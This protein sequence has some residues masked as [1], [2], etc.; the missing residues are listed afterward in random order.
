MIRATLFYTKPLPKNLMMFNLGCINRSPNN[1][2]VRTKSSSPNMAYCTLSIHPTN[3]PWLYSPCGCWPLFQFL[4]LFTDNRTPWTGDQPV[5]RPLPT[6]RTQTQ[7]KRTQTS[8]P[9]VGFEPMTPVFERAKMVHALDRAATVNGSL[10]STRNRNTSSSFGD[11]IYE[12]TLALR[13]S[14]TS[15]ANNCLINSEISCLF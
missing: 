12:N 8:M 15:E 1:F 11:K 7:N 14:P 2:S 6:H 10:Y 13:S 5:A 4:N 9:R 3:H